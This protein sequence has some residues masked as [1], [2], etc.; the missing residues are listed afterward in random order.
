M[1]VTARNRCLGDM[2]IGQWGCGFKT[3]SGKCSTWVFILGR[4]KPTGDGGGGHVPFFFLQLNHKKMLGKS[5][6]NKI[7]S[8]RGKFLPSSQIRWTVRSFSPSFLFH[9]VRGVAPWWLLEKLHVGLDSSLAI[10]EFLGELHSTT[11]TGSWYLF[12]DK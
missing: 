2:F 11:K 1:M 7:W 10:D 6:R 8:S 9:W 5:S 4:H 12:L 3:Q